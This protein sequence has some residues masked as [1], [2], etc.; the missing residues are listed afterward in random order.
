M[1]SF[2]IYRTVAEWRTDMGNIVS[3]ASTY[4]NF[5]GHDFEAEVEYYI[6]SLGSPF[7]IDYENGG[8]PGWG[9]EWS[10]QDIFLMEDRGLDGMGPAFKVTGKLFQ[11]L[12]RNPKIENAIN[13]DIE[14]QN[15]E[16]DY[17]Y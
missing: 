14:S 8:E 2:A 10:I 7:I 9:P 11:V 6:E 12:A 1:L 4:I 13:T 5:M 3:S 17:C 16:E 15:Y